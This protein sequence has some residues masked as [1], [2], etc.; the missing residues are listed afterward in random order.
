VS[1]I[2]DGNTGAESSLKLNRRVVLSAAGLTGVALV[3]SACGST[4]TS[5]KSPSPT[6]KPSPTA[7][8]PEVL[9]STMA[10]P[11]GGGVIYPNQAVVVTQPTAGVYKGFSAICP[12]QG[13]TVG[14]IAQGVIICPCHLSTFSITDGSVKQ[15]PAQTGLQVVPV[16]VVGTDIVVA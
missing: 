1:D 9:G 6:S 5:A 8:T 3:V 2:E 16:K 13:C 11:V 12:H 4:G 10:I 15:G 14:Q 7:S